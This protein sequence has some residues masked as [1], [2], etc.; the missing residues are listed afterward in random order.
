MAYISF[1]FKADA[2]FWTKASRL[3]LK[4]PNI[5]WGSSS[6]ILAMASSSVK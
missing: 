4:A 5:V 2:I 3:I 6:T 1:E